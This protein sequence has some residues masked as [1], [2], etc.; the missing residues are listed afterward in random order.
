MLRGSRPPVAGFW[1][2]YH[3]QKFLKNLKNL[4][5]KHWIRVHFHAENGD[6]LH[7]VRYLNK[8]DP[9]NMDNLRICLQIIMKFQLASGNYALSYRPP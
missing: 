7:C 1:H 4:N 2:A 3:S 5:V 9:C 8:G 6:I